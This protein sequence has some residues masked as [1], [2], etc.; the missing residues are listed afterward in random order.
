MEICHRHFGSWCQKEL[1]PAGCVGLQA[2]H[3]LLKFRQ[4]CG[5]NHAITPDQKRWTNLEIPMLAR[6]QIEHELDQGALQSRS[7]ASETDKSTATEFRCPFQVEQ[8]QPGSD[9]NVIERISD[10]RFLLPLPHH[11]V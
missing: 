1:I 5:P 11:W 10:F 7:G 6:V 3:V 2:V 8:L 9:G 4:L